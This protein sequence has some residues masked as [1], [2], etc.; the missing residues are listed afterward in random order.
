MK[1][2]KKLF[3]LAVL[4]PFLSLLN[5]EIFGGS[6]MEISSS[7]FKD[8]GKIPIQY[9]MLG[10]E[11][12]NVS[13]PLSWKNIPHWYKILCPFDSG[14]SSCGSKLGSLISD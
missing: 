14:Y 3:L 12:K 9:V 11:G 7:A 13:L 2:L 5:H 6:A 1:I 10:A 8:G 4:V